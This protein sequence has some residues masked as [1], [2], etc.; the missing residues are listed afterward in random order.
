MVS[1]WNF[2]V[3][4]FDVLT[5]GVLSGKCFSSIDPSGYLVAEVENQLLG[6]FDAASQKGDLLTMGDRA[7]IL[8]QVRGQLLVKRM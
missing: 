1:T 8:S 3:P 2:E 4:Y 7:K 5:P 6:Q